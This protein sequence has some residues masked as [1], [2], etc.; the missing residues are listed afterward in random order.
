MSDDEAIDIRVASVL[1][2]C[3]VQQTH[4]QIGFLGTVDCRRRQLASDRYAEIACTRLKQD[5]IM[6]YISRGAQLARV[7]D[8]SQRII[9]GG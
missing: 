5:S 9:R 4:I 6:P 1:P 2:S 7:T 3:L 8:K